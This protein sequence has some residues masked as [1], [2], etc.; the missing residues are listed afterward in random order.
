MKKIMENL[1]LACVLCEIV[2]TVACLSGVTLL[3]CTQ[4]SHYPSD[5]H[6]INVCDFGAS[7]SILYFFGYSF[8][9]TSKIF[10]KIDAEVEAVLS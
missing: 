8:Y 7:L 9:W 6:I 4:I 3:A 2:A 10:Q 1:F 5:V